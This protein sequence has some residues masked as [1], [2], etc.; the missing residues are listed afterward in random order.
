MS[1]AAPLPGGVNVRTWHRV[2]ILWRDG[3]WLRVP[4][5][6]EKPSSKDF[7]PF[8]A[9]WR[10]SVFLRRTTAMMA[11]P[12]TRASAPLPRLLTGV[13]QEHPDDGV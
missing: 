12:N 1:D 11:N 5:C 6:Q 3:T 7:V 8:Q 9:I 2:S 13:V 10:H 4:S